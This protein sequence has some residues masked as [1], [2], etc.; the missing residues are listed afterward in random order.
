MY[1]TLLGKALEIILDIGA[2]GFN[3]CIYI[4]DFCPFS[5]DTSY[6]ELTVFIIAII[7]ERRIYAHRNR[8]LPL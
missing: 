5:V 1:I 4:F 3:F 2:K 8:H 7:I 6:R